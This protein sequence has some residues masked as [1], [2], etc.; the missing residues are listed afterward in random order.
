MNSSAGGGGEILRLTD[1]N[2]KR[3]KE[4]ILLYMIDDNVEAKRR[5]AKICLAHVEEASGTCDREILE[6]SRILNATGKCS[7]VRNEDRD[8]KEKTTRRSID[9]RDG[10]IYRLKTAKWD[11]EP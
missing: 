11:A 7:L 6:I 1:N 8:K 10:K 5:F 9:K 3:A 2:E 4:K